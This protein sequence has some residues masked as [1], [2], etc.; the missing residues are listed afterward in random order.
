M[1]I[2]AG[3]NGCV[4]TACV[5]EHKLELHFCND[6]FPNVLLQSVMAKSWFVIVGHGCY[7]NG[8]CIDVIIPILYSNSQQRYNCISRYSLIIQ[9]VVFLNIFLCIPLR[10]LE[11]SFYL[12]RTLQRGL[13]G[14][15]ALALGRWLSL[16]GKWGLKNMGKILLKNNA[17]GLNH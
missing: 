5:V 2:H 8:R 11:T 4:A 6:F 12:W 10:S 3:G 14:V 16:A 9:G 15:G 13:H 1:S 7:V 17:S